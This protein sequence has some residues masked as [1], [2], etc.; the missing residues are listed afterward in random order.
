MAGVGS[1]HTE[2]VGR[3]QRAARL[4]EVLRDR[5]GRIA[6]CEPAGRRLDML[7]PGYRGDCRLAD[8]AIARGVQMIN[9]LARRVVA[10]PVGTHL[11]AIWADLEGLAVLGLTRGWRR[12]LGR[13][14]GDGEVG[15]DAVQ[16]LQN[17]GLGFLDAGGGG[18][19]GY[20][21]ADPQRE[22]QRDEDG[23]AHPATLFAA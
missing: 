8:R 5:D 15:A 22:T 16:R 10:L 17:L 6:Q 19:H 3:W 13:L 11:C 1:L 2:R 12:R 9:R 14:A 4:A 7:Q 20:D 18:G 21:Q 23:L